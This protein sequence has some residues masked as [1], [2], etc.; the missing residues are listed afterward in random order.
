MEQFDL[1][2]QYKLYLERVGLKEEFLGE[3]QKRE[4]KRAFMGACGQILILLRD[5]LSLL[6]DDKALEKMESMTGQVAA[7]WIGEQITDRFNRHSQSIKI[8]E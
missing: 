1:N 5:D 3:D 7:F 6:D 2:Y 4:L 8:Y